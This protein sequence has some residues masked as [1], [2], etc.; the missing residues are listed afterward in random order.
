MTDD[1][2]Q[3]GLVRLHPA[4]VSGTECTPGRGWRF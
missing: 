3:Q 4:V 1:S 2:A